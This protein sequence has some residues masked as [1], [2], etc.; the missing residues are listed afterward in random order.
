MVRDFESDMSW[1]KYSNLR[2]SGFSVSFNTDAPGIHF[3][4]LNNAP[5]YDHDN[6]TV[7]YNENFNYTGLPDSNK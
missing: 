3:I 6:K 7:V 1:Y 4:A 5:V 2:Q